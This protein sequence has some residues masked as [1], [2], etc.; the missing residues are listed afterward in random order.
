MNEVYKAFKAIEHGIFLFDP[1]ASI[2]NVVVASAIL[3]S[4]LIRL[5]END[6]IRTEMAHEVSSWINEEVGHA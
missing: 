6:N 2:P 5:E 4:S 1:N 3:I